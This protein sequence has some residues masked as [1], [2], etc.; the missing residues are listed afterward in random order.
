MSGNPSKAVIKGLGVEGWK[1]RLTP[2]TVVRNPHDFSYAGARLCHAV[3]QLRPKLRQPL[4][5][6][7]L[8]LTAIQF[9]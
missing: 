9:Y 8:D 2:H 3:A 6:R 1:I 7:W 5:I 4:L